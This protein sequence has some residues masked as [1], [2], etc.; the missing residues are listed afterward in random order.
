L[1]HK[2]QV[3]APVLCF[4][5]RMFVRICVMPFNDMTDVERLIAGVD[6]LAALPTGSHDYRLLD[7]EKFEF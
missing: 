5:A 2:H 4:G 3:V 6:A 7:D 1:Y